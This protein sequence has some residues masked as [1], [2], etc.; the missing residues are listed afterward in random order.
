MLKLENGIISIERLGKVIEV[1]VGILLKVGIPKKAGI[2]RL[3]NSV[4]IQ[5]CSGIYLQ[6]H[7]Y[8]VYFSYKEYED[9]LCEVRKLIGITGL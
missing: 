8:R 4:T 3:S 7:G 6:S 5:K 9:L 1:D 2:L